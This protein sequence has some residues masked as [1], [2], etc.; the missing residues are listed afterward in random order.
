MVNINLLTPGFTSP[1]GCEFLFPLIYHE[2][3]LRDFK[4]FV[5]KTFLL[6]PN[7]DHLET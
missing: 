2:Y 1:N 5:S 3:L 7:M 4:G 6:K